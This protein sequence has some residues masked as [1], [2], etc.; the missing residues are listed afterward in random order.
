MKPGAQIPNGSLN[1]WQRDDIKKL[2]AEETQTSRIST[3][4]LLMTMFVCLLALLANQGLEIQVLKQQ[5]EQLQKEK[6]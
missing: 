4:V 2:I 5:V 3:F 1:P 6:P